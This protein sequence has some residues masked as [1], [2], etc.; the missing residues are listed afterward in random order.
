[1][2]LH[3]R[4]TITLL[5]MPDLNDILKNYYNMDNVLLIIGFQFRLLKTKTNTV[6]DITS[7]IT[8]LWSNSGNDIIDKEM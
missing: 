6:Q 4:K 1:M 5:S 7:T 3:F 2:D 8:S